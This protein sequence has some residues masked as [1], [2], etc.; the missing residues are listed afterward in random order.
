MTGVMHSSASFL[1][2]DAWRGGWYELAIKLGP[3]SDDR[4]LQTARWVWSRSDLNGPY[5]FSDVEPTRQDRVPVD[6]DGVERLYGVAHIPGWIPA[7]CSSV[8]IREEGGA[9]WF[10]LGLPLGALGAADDRVGGYPFDDGAETGSDWTASLDDWLAEIALGLREYVPFEIAMI[11]FEV[12][13]LDEVL[14][15][16]VSEG[17]PTGAYVDSTGYHKAR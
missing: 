9:D 10:D 5:G 7:V 16:Q 3:R 8:V 4:L 1:A 2:P 14:A 13:G 12:S 11:G 6:L 17:R 15:W